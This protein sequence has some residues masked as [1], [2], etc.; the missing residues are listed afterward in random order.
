[1]LRTIGFNAP[2]DLGLEPLFKRHVD[3]DPASIDYAR[4]TFWLR[5]L[6]Y[7]VSLWLIF[8]YDRSNVAFIYFQF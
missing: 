4:W 8:M 5:P 6:T 7:S 3:R 1:M 2:H